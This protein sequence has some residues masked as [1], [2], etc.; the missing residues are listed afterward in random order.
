VFD[1]ISL[2]LL[3]KLFS[4]TGE[5]SY[6]MRQK[7]RFVFNQLKLEFNMFLISLVKGRVIVDSKS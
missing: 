5:K 7:L 3:K 2:I 1:C 6:R 4:F